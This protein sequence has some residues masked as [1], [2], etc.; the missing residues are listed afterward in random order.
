[1]LI[2]GNV[3]APSASA[4]LTSSTNAVA[5]MDQQGALATTAV[6]GPQYFGNKLI[7]NVFMASIAYGSPITIPENANNL[8]SKFC[9]VNPVGSGKVLELIDLDIGLVAAATAAAFI[10]VYQT[11]ASAISGLSATTVGTIQSGYV[12]GSVASVCTFYS[13]ATHVGT[14]VQLMTIAAQQSTSA[15]QAGT[16]HYEFKGKIIIPPGTAI[17]LAASAAG[18]ASGAIPTLTWN[19]WPI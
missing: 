15:L 14:P 5:L 17:D 7:Q 10:L 13:A 6:H 11:G 16:L 8:V 19:E 1:M 4:S 18:P 9:L 2:Q 12:G 3:G